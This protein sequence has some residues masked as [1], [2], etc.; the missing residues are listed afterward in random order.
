M[1]TPVTRGIARY[2]RL[3]LAAAADFQALLDWLQADAP[4]GSMVETTTQVIGGPVQ[5]P[6]PA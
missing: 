3:I 4:R 6:M 1:Q 2:A 5:P